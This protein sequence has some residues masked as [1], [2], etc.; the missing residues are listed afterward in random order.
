[1]VSSQR[2]EVENNQITTESED[3]LNENS[4]SEIEDNV[5]T[6]E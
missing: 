5:T 6:E 2:S 1:M 4:D 3:E